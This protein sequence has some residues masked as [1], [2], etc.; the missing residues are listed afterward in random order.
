MDSV[1]KNV[2]YDVDSPACYGGVSIVY[3]EAKKRLNKIT[4]KNVKEFLARQQ[5]YTLHKPVRRKFPRN[6]IVT[7]GLDVDW[8]S[9][10]ADLSALKSYN[11]NYS[12]L[13]I[14]VD[15]LSRFAWVVPIKRKTP[16][17][18]KEAFQFI[19]AQ[20][21]RK[22]WRLCTDRGREYT[23]KVFQDFLTETY[24]QYFNPNNPDVK[25]AIAERYIRTLKSRLW[26]YFTRMKTFRY[27]EILPSIVKS[28]NNTVHRTTGKRPVEIN[29]SNESETWHHLYDNQGV[30]TTKFRFNIGDHVRISAEK[31]KLQKGYLPNYTD[32]IFIVTERL[33]HRKPVAYRIADL[34]A[35]PIEGIFYEPELVKVIQTVGPY[36]EIEKIIRSQKRD[37]LLYHL[38][39]WKNEPSNKKS[40]VSE[41][42][43]VSL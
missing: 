9:D 16:D 23:G 12:F 6:K 5:T 39:K 3:K 13:V 41:K 21:G 18:V 32:E 7:A 15:V 20:S 33:K 37:G 2:Y 24:I 19:F 42:E 34:E 11:S 29:E 26:R 30:D 22:P 10:L 1:L 25:A 43:L 38:V 27:L 28:I 31:S 8:Q 14:C 35:E 36:R 4:L 40:W 17:Q